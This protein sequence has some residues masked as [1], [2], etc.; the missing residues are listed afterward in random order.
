[1]AVLT[2]LALQF[3]AVQTCVAGAPDDQTGF[4]RALT[5]L[6]MASGYLEDFTPSKQLNEQLI[7]AIT[8]ID[9]AISEK[10]LSNIDDGE[11]TE[12]HPAIDSMLTRPE[13]YQ[14]AV[15]LLIKIRSDINKGVNKS[16]ASGLQS[17]VSSR[18]DKALAIMNA[19]ILRS[20]FHGRH[21]AYLEALS[22]LREARE[23]LNK[24]TPDLKV[25]NNELNAIGEINSAM[26]DI[27]TAAITGG[28]DVADAPAAGVSKRKAARYGKALSLLNKALQSIGMAEDDE[29]AK[30]PQKLA[31]RHINNAVDII[32]RGENNPFMFLGSK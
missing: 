7:Y 22:F 5:D 1:M 12:F 13:R 21:P 31:L 14:E 3:S 8:E 26:S 23:K 10:S 18:I 9:S 2:A 16:L 29:F 28:T 32:K 27:K 15:K 11:D 30:D 6:R 19:V 17:R 20:N 4:I 24:I 25:D